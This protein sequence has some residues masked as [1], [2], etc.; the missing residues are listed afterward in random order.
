MSKSFATELRPSGQPVTLSSLD[1]TGL[2]NA[3]TEKGKAIP[4]PAGDYNRVL[5]LA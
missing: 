1:D 5:V 2:S 4:M 3:V